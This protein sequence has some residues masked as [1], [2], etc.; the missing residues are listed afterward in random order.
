MQTQANSS[1]TAQIPSLSRG[2][3]MVLMVFIIWAAQAI[4]KWTLAITADGETSAKI[5]SFFITPRAEQA[6][7][8]NKPEISTGKLLNG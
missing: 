7:A 3:K 4:P 8:H 6:I 1:I 2:K 5:I